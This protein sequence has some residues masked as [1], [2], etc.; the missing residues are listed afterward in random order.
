MTAYNKKINFHLRDRW[1]KKIFK[2]QTL[3]WVWKN[4][5]RSVLILFR[6]SWHNLVTVGQPDKDLLGSNNSSLLGMLLWLLNF[7]SCHQN[8]TR[9]SFFHFEPATPLRFLFWCRASPY[10][11]NFYHNGL[12]CTN[13]FSSAKLVLTAIALTN[14]RQMYQ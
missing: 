14:E 3:D 6:N 5:T 10:A 4:E 1:D 2:K 12:V 8:K 9:K 13:S 11:V 7:F